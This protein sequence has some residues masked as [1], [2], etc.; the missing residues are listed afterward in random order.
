[1]LVFLCAVVGGHRLAR[2]HRLHAA[3]HQPAARLANRCT[4]TGKPL[5]NRPCLD[6]HGDV[7]AGPGRHTRFWRPGHVL[8]GRQRKIDRRRRHVFGLRFRRREPRSQQPAPRTQVRILAGT[9]PQA[10]QQVQAGPLVQLLAALGRS[11]RPPA[12]GE[13]CLPLRGPPQRRGD[14]L[15]GGP[16]NA[17]GHHK[18]TRG[19]E[20][21]HGFRHG[22]R[23]ATNHPCGQRS[24][25][26]GDRGSGP[27]NAPASRQATPANGH[28][29]SARRR[30]RKDAPDRFATR[31]GKP[32][33]AVRRN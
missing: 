6:R 5:P 14:H 27:R 17:A 13:P 33:A 1:M 25:M 11:R 3:C 28:H 10:L 16:Q 21:G 18:P 23:L 24:S 15:Q 29:R 26:R 8:Q 19:W 7:A 20:V 2:T 32:R 30:G 31:P 12:P 22:I 9:T 4:R